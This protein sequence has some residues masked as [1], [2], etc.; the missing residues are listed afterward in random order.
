METT[1]INVCSS[2]FN[3]KYQFVS[4]MIDFRF[5]AVRKLGP[6]QALVSGPASRAALSQLR[7][8][9]EWLVMEN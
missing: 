9:E 6:Q 3:I 1:V 5:P 2:L 8:G 7:N 4:D